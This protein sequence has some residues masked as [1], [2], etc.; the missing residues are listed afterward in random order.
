MTMAEATRRLFVGNL[1][2]GVADAEV[3]RA[4]EKFGLVASL[5]LKTKKAADGEVLSTFAFVD[6]TASDKQ[7]SKCEF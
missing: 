2:N 6:L 7:L 3:R 4:F 5:E 1:P